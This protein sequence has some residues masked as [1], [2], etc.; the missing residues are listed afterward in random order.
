L[1]EGPGERQREAGPSAATASRP[2]VSGVVCVGSGVVRVGVR[3][4]S[5]RLWA[6]GVLL[7]FPVNAALVAGEDGLT[8]VDAGLAMMGRALVRAIG[9]TGLPLRRVV[10]TH[11]HFDHIGGLRAVLA[12]WRVPVLAHPDE[13]PFLRGER[14][15]ARRRPPGRPLVE[16]GL[17]RA[18]AAGE[19]PG[20]LEPRHCPGH[21]AGHTAYWLAEESVLLAGD[22]FSAYLPGRLGRPTPFLTDDM[23][24]AVASGALVLSLRPERMLVCHGGVVRW[25]H[26]LYPAYRRTHLKRAEGGR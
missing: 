11:G 16:P 5:P 8:L 3:R 7:P 6:V 19:R 14:G 15:Y 22:L 26:L 17:L 10:L 2:A 21:T 1:A 24:R 20:G 25:P 12:A 13:M 23:A 18:L 4:L 9:A